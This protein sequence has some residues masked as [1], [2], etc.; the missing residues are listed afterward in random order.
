MRSC[1]HCTKTG[2][3]VNGDNL[4]QKAPHWHFIEELPHY[5]KKDADGKHDKTIKY[6]HCTGCH[7]DSSLILEA[8]VRQTKMAAGIFRYHSSGSKKNGTL[9]S[10][11]LEK[12][13]GCKSKE[14]H[15]NFQSVIK[16]EQQ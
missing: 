7:P 5:A 14:L 15:R 16:V 12:S 13:I 4:E 9:F 2:A 8:D 11:H 3:R 1:W 10:Q 6:Y